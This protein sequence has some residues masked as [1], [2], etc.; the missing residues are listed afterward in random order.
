MAPK[1][2][3]RN[4]IAINN[5]LVSISQHLKSIFKTLVTMKKLAHLF[6]I[7]LLS[8][9]GGND[10]TIALN[11]EAPFEF[12]GNWLGSWSD[13][14]FPNIQVSAKVFKAGSNTYI[15]SF[16]YGVNGATPYNPCCGAAADGNI[17][18]ETDGN[19]VLNFSI[20]QTAPDY[21]GGC[22]GTYSGSGEIIL[23]ANRLQIIF[24][25]EDCDGFHDKGKMTW[26]L[27]K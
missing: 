4:L 20:I 15:G 27:D 22:P 21:K 12:E 18:F 24:T 10:E 9:C 16:Y 14:L 11:T 25:G 17:R 19:K 6:I 23:I 8:S 3:F 2:I 1:I 13:S 5:R 7:I 26:K